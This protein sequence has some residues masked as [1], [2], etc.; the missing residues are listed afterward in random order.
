M[1]NTLRILLIDDNPRDRALVMRTLRKEFPDLQ[2]EEITEAEGF[3]CALEKGDFD[4]V[5]T[6]YQLR[7]TDGIAV[8]HAVKDR[9]PD[10]PVVMFTGTGDEETAVEALKIALIT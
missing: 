2:V 6:D 10:C 9:Y 8:L 3:G 7:W 4:I 1:N 5:I